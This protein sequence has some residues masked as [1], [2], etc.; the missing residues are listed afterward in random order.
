M[1]KLRKLKKKLHISNDRYTSLGSRSY[2]DLVFIL[3]KL[4]DYKPVLKLPLNENKRF[5]VAN[6]LN[7]LNEDYLLYN[8][9]LLEYLIKT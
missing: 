3:D 4:D 1:N 8:D 5:Q 2:C 7:R 6:T 9:Q